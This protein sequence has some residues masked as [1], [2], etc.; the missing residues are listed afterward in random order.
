MKAGGR[1]KPRQSD[2]IADD[3][4]RGHIDNDPCMYTVSQNSDDIFLLVAKYSVKN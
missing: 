3:Y 2:G 1:R 4:A